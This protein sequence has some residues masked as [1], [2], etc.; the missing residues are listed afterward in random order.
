MNSPWRQGLWLATDGQLAVGGYG[1]AVISV[2]LVGL[3]DSRGW[4]LLQ[5]RDEHA[6]TDPDKWSLV[7]GGVEPGEPADAAARR[8]LAEETGIV[9]NDLVPLGRHIMPSTAHGRVR[10]DLFTARTEL[11]DADVVCGEGRQI[12]FVEPSVVPTLDLTDATRALFRS[13]PAG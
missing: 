5:E 10:V 9:C 11:T 3:V 13:V 7:G 12:V 6:P 1:E 8:E 2:V 4:L